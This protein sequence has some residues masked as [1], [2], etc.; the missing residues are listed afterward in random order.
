MSSSVTEAIK[1]SSTTYRHH[2]KLCSNVSL[3]EKTMK[4]L[5]H[6][7]LRKQHMVECLNYMYS[8]YRREA[9]GEGRVEQPPPPNAGGGWGV[10]RIFMKLAY[11]LTFRITQ[12]WTFVIR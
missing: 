9:K 2:K 6:T 12:S 10:G 8:T 4:T 1:M 11:S 7:F 3:N 5:S